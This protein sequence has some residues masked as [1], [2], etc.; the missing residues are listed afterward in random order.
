MPFDP[1]SPKAVTAAL[2]AA[3][4]RCPAC[5]SS[6]LFVRAIGRRAA[7]YCDGCGMKSPDVRNPKVNEETGEVEPVALARQL[8]AEF[9]A[10]YKPF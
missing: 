8:T 7:I 2:A 1:S 5:E 9:P 4:F 10:V 6:A 3:G